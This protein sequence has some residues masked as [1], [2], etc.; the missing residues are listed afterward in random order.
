MI[1]TEYLAFDLVGRSASGKTEIWTVGSV[2]QGAELGQVRWFGRWRQYA[3]FPGPETAFNAKCLRDV[4]EVCA[5]L[6]RD[7]LAGHD[8]GHHMTPDWEDCA[9]CG[10]VRRADR[11]NKKCPRVMPKIGL[12]EA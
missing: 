12:R 5:D 2:R 6:T 3:F 4:A 8:W 7:H 1:S 11:K 9:L 10:I